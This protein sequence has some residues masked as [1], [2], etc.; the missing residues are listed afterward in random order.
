MLHAMPADVRIHGFRVRNA[1]SFPGGLAAQLRKVGRS[2]KVSDSWDDTWVSIPSWHR[3]FGFSSWLVTRQIR[4]AIR[5]FGQPDVILFT[6]PWY[7]GVVGNFPGVTKA[8]YAYDPYRFYEWNSAKIIPLEKR[9]LDGC[10]V[11][12]GVAKLLV[13][14]LQA[15]TKTPVHYLPNAAQRQLEI[16]NEEAVAAAAKDFESVPD[17]RVG[18][19][20]Q[21]N[22][23]VYDWDLVEQLSAGFPEVQFIFIGPKFDERPS[24]ATERMQTF[25]SRPN[26]H[27]LG[28][29]P[30]AH[31]PAYL[32]QCKILISPL[33]VND[34]N[35]RRSLLRL[36]DYLTTDRLIISTG[37]AE[38]FNHVPYIFVAK[39]NEDFFRLLGEALEMPSAP[40]QEGRRNYIE[41]NTWQARAEE[42][43]RR[44]DREIV[45]GT[46]KSDP[47]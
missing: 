3:A 14:D 34:H 46:G 39:D 29:K 10:D 20:G 47:Q 12:F 45:R 44:I 41:A 16:T 8:Y 22:S 4:K 23:S 11:G 38:A 30:H 19:V 31:L 13:E 24:P 15:V 7:A 26:V 18:C 33:L 27:W 28:P 35:N 1:F 2:E 25:F 43:W 17:P 9:I 21:I 37:I 42:F 40:D 32:S 5:R 6:L 36:F